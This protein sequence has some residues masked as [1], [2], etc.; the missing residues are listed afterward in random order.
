MVHTG[1]LTNMEII[2]VVNSKT[3][4]VRD[5]GGGFFFYTESRLRQ[6]T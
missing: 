5:A 4:Q 3:P 2:Q 1:H 6:E